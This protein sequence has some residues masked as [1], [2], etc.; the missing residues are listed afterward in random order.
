MAV[1]SVQRQRIV[2]FPGM[3]CETPE[4]AEL[5]QETMNNAQVPRIPCE[6]AEASVIRQETMNE[7]VPHP[8]RAIVC[9]NKTEINARRHS[10]KK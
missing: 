3:P 2:P 5:R 4:E 10:G 9:K 8:R 1:R 7:D 6:S